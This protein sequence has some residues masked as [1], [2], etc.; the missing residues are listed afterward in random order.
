MHRHMAPHTGAAYVVISHGPT[1]GGAYTSQGG[2]VPT[3][4]TMDGTEEQRNYANVAFDA[5]AYYVDGET[6]DTA[7]ATHFDDIVLRPSIL[8]VIAKAGLAA[9]TH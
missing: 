7:D 9:R 2:L 1:G 8:N 3:T 6:S 4:A 5:N